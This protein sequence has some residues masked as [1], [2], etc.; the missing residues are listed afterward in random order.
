MITEGPDYVRNDSAGADLAVF[1]RMVDDLG[2]DELI[3]AANRLSDERYADLVI[4][5]AHKWVPV[6]LADKPTDTA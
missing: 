4:S 1:V 2:A 5:T 6:V 3:H